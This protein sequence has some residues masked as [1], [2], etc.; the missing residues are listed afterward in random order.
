MPSVV[1]ILQS[2]T[3]A[4]T[5]GGARLPVAGPRI[6]ELPDGRTRVDTDSQIQELVRQAQA[7][8]QEAFGALYERLAPKIY[9]YLYYRVGADAQIAEDLT[10]DVFLKVL[11]KLDSYQDR[12]LPF[13][14]WV[15]RIARN[16]L[17][18]HVRRLPKE[19]DVRVDD[20][21]DV[22]EAAAQQPFELALVRGDLTSALQRLTA[23]QRDVIILRFLQ[24]ATLA[25]TAERLGKS[26]DAVKKLQA[27]GLQ[28][29]R[30]ALTT[31]ALAERAA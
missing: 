19:P 16:R 15:Y 24:D 26:H 2:G 29:L 28:G 27:R 5:Q 18:D 13:Q 3:E 14:A 6:L 31:S 22:A 30:R 17:I 12:G 25:E 11:A 1:L 21:L 20:Q 7:G 8:S 23:D 4:D 10:E 9:A